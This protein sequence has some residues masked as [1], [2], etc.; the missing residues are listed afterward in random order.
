M[1]SIAPGGSGFSGRGA[2]RDGGQICCIAEARLDAWSHLTCMILDSN[3]LREIQA[4]RGIFTPRFVDVREFLAVVWGLHLYLCAM[5]AFLKYSRD[6]RARESVVVGMS[7]TSAVGIGEEYPQGV[8]DQRNG[9]TAIARFPAAA[10]VVCRS[11]LRSS[12][13]VVPR[14]P[15]PLSL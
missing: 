15:A 3:I 9:V 11:G 13:T 5:F 10:R 2:D 6:K 12:G 14:P 8:L 1:N 4:A 7:G